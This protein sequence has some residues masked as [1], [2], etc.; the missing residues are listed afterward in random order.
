[1]NVTLAPLVTPGPSP[2]PGPVLRSALMGIQIHGYLKDDEWMRMLAYTKDLG[3]GWIK[4]QVQWKELE[5]A[6]GVFNEL[7]N[8]MVLNVQRAR[9]QGLHTMISIAKAPGWARPQAVFETE[10]GPPDNYQDFADFVA[11]FIRDCKPEFIDAI[12]LW[13]EPNLIRE[14]RGKP[15]NGG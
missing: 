15:L 12:E 5:P 4:V 3:M 2:T 14:W 9:I 6:K 13:N 8:A 7:Y 10:D 1:A 11:R